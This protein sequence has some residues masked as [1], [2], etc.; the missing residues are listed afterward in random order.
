MKKFLYLIIGVVIFSSCNSQVDKATNNYD[1]LKT[2]VVVP[3]SVQIGKEMKA[4]IYFNR[5]INDEIQVELNGI[6]ANKIVIEGEK[7]T[8][9]QSC[10]VAGEY[11]VT[12]KINLIDKNKKVI[13]SAPVEFTYVVIPPT[14]RIKNADADVSL[15]VNQENNIMFSVAAITSSITTDNGTVKMTGAGRCI[16]IPDKKGT[17]TLSIIA[18][19]VKVGEQQF[20]VK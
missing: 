16:V 13:A 15:K 10:S 20:S 12:G 11:T 3:N 14:F 8:V 4:E 6:D 1:G 7:V 18:D 9:T 2:I 17:C 19:D 5:K